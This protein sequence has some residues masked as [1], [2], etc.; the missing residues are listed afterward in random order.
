MPNTTLKA[1]D[2]DATSDATIS[3]RAV[4][5]G[6]AAAGLAIPLATVAQAEGAHDHHDHGGTHHRKLIETALDCVGRGDSCAAHCV[7]LMGDGDTSLKD[8]L[9]SVNAMLP[10]C[11]TL[12]RYAA[13]DAK[14][15]KQLAKVCIDI[16]DDCAK[17]CETH[18]AEH[19]VCKLCGESCE[20][21]I[22]ACENL[23][24]A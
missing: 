19:E 23:V 7:E 5:A 18:A 16:C 6:T 14:R 4:L 9:V 3:R 8:C 24:T 15:L 21:C 11:A 13:S 10:M 17:A 1:R 22:K 2:A 20:A 12:A